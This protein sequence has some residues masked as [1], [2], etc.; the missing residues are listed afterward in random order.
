MR[1]RWGHEDFMKDMV[2]SRRMSSMNSYEIKSN[3]MYYMKYIHIMKSCT[4][5]DFKCWHPGLSWTWQL[6]ISSFKLNRTW[7]GAR[8]FGIFFWETSFY[9]RIRE[10]Q[11]EN[12]CYCY[13]L[14]VMSLLFDVKKFD[15]PS[16]VTSFYFPACRPHLRIFKIISIVF[17]HL[18]RNS[19]AANFRQQIE[20]PKCWRF[21]C[22]DHELNGA[23]FEGVDH[24]QQTPAVRGQISVLHNVQLQKDL[25]IHLWMI[26]NSIIYIV[27]LVYAQNMISD[28][29]KIF[30]QF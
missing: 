25:K 24:I 23:A 19:W 4:S 7:F 17:W 15:I 26:L 9:R 18:R 27:W 2:N 12:K 30:R 3:I 21:E 6:S 13:L 16:N 10:F 29:L 14:T 28:Y 1:K 11:M 5:R 22:C 8:W 20:R